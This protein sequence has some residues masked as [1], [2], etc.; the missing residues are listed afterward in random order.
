MRYQHIKW[1]D[2][3]IEK[4]KDMA[5]RRLSTGVMARTLGT[6][7]NSVIGKAHREGIKLMF[8]KRGRNANQIVIDKLIHTIEQLSTQE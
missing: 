5:E 1:T 2:D 7:R 4:L 8:F 3:Q 6:T